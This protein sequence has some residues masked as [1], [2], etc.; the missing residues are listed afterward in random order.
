[1]PDSDATIQNRLSRYV[2]RLS[3]KRHDFFRKSRQKLGSVATNGLVDVRELMRRDVKLPSVET[4]LGPVAGTKEQRQ[5]DESL[6]K[7]KKL[8]EIVS[9]S[10]EILASAQSA[11][12][13]FPDSVVVDRSMITITR[14]MFFW[15]TTAISIRVEDVLNVSTSLGPIFGSL[16]ISSRVMNSTDHFQI[17]FFWRN[18]AIHLKHIIQG[19]MI[20]LHNNIET[21]HLGRDELIRTLAE[22]GEESKA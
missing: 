12:N 8:K 19:Y 10:H 15:S 17:N 5:H 22:L 6:R 21:D 1:M 7:I 11:L 18:D 13:P 4:L 3:S 16:N 9:R 14:R 2:S 20:A